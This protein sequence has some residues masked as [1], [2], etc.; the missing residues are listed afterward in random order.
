MPPNSSPE[1]IQHDDVLR[2][3]AG[4][5]HDY[6][7]TVR[8]EVTRRHPYYLAFWSQA[9]LYR[10]NQLGDPPEQRLLRWSAA[11][12]LGAIGVTGEP[13]DPATSADALLGQHPDP[14]FLAGSVQP[15]TL[16][17]VV[18]MLISALPPAERSFVGHLL[19]VSAEPEYA[20]AGDDT[21]A[22]AQKR[23]AQALLARTP[24]TALDSCPDAPLFFVHVGASS[25]SITRD[26]Q[27][28][29]RRWKQR[30][31]FGERRAHT[32][33]LPTYL[34]VWDRRE[35]W[36]QGGYELSRERPFADIAAEL[37]EPLS[38][39]VNRYRSA[40]EMVTGHP[41]APELWCRLF[42]PLK[43]AMAC[44]DPTV[45]F[46]AS[47]RHRLQSPVRR[48]VPDSVVSPPT[49]QAHTSGTVERI[50]AVSDST[51]LTDLLIDF[52]EMV[53]RQVP[54]GEIARRLGFGDADAV[55]ALRARLDEFAEP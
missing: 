31:G 10:R 4:Q 1:E 20:E 36:V 45:V 24:S 54:D 8:W 30:R 53:G 17:S 7:V 46:S 19:S 14:A 29:A 25:R 22:T 28:Q 34:A 44:G 2:R 47:T 55:A 21:Q 26:V 3:P 11:L 49:D 48:P 52:K 40:F 37:G 32:D 35:G 38:T 43:Y 5:L 42:V 33:K 6:P 16:R 39:V 41:F 27:D 9:L 23:K 12:I 13:V 50:S 51:E 15:M 18:A